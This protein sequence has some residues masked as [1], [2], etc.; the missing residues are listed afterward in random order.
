MRKGK[1]VGKILKNTLDTLSVKR[2]RGRPKAVDPSVV[3]GRADNYR[4]WLENNWKGVGV[5]LLEAQ[6]RHD[7]AEALEGGDSGK[8]ELFSIAHV[9]LDAINE[10]GFPK[11]PKAQIKFIADSIAGRGVVTPRRSRDICA[12]QRKMDQNKHIILRYEYWIEC[13]CGYEGHSENHSC[14]KCG[15]L[16][17]L[18]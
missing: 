14:K 8:D 7:I 1:K 4:I 6:T 17:H 18:P 11:G 9:I 16:L 2:G 15:A 10:P 13:S 12:K 3:R 5:L